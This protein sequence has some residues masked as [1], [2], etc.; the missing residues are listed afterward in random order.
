MGIQLP[1]PLARIATASFISS[2]SCRD[3]GPTNSVVWPKARGLKTHSLSL[4]RAPTRDGRLGSARNWM[5]S[6]GLLGCLVAVAEK[7]A[8]PGRA[9]AMV[10]FT[11]T[12]TTA[13]PGR[14]CTPDH[15]SASVRVV[16]LATIR[17]VRPAEQGQN[18]GSL[19]G[20]IRD[21]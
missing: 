19:G 12:S 14:P 21:P 20:A 17:W 6:G 9:L 1:W 10:M 11:A 4:S 5:Q 7:L 18:Q 15:S 8:R 13:P 2:S 3:P 16:A